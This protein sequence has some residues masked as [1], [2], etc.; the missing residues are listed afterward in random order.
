MLSREWRCSWSC[1]DGRCSNYIWEIIKKLSPTKVPLI[2]RFWQY[3]YKQWTAVWYLQSYHFFCPVRYSG[4]TWAPWRPKSSLVRSTKIQSSAMLPISEGNPPIP[5]WS[6][7]TKGSE[8]GKEF[9]S[10]D[11]TMPFV[12][13]TAIL[14]STRSDRVPMS[15]QP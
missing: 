8:M 10:R 1:A 14:P 4:V 3:M 9:P 6:P 13:S 5:S 7:Y 2:L 11:I 15:V 12:W